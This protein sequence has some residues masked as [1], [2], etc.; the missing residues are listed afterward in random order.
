MKLVSS[1]AVKILAPL[2]FLGAGA[3]YVWQWSFASGP[4]PVALT[5]RFGF[6]VALIAYGAYRLLQA[7]RG[8]PPKSES[9]D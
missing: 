5:L 1:R 2:L 8:T 4:R 9:G 7:W 6:G 3:W